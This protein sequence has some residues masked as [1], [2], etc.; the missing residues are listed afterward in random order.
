M[1]KTPKAHN[2]RQSGSAM[3]HLKLVAAS[4]ALSLAILSVGCAAAIP[5]AAAAAALASRLANDKCKEIYKREPF[6]PELYRAR[7]LE[8]RWNW[9]EYDPAG[10]EGFSAEVSFARDGSDAQVQI[11]FSTDI[12]DWGDSE[13]DVEKDWGPTD[14]YES[15]E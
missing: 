11:H 4:A 9:G 15:S 5:D 14:E 13:D 2:A 10:P 12:E 7:F 3:L 8:G 6:D 1:N